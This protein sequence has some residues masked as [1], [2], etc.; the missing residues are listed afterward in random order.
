MKKHTGIFSSMF[1]PAVC[2]PAALHARL[3]RGAR[4][5]PAP[6]GYSFIELPSRRSRFAGQHSA[7]VVKSDNKL[8]TP[9]IADLYCDLIIV[10]EI[11]QQYRCLCGGCRLHLYQKKDYLRLLMSKRQL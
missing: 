1:L 4:A 3:R 5:E 2:R 6:E 8:Q 11:S 10:G 9:E 7:V